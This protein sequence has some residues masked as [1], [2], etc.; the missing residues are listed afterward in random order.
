MIIAIVVSRITQFRAILAGAGVGRLLDFGSLGIVA[1]W[2]PELRGDEITVAFTHIVSSP[3]A[4]IKHVSNLLCACNVEI[5][6]AVSDSP[7]GRPP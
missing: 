7:S 2:F 6:R 1:Q 3:L 5:V 4:C